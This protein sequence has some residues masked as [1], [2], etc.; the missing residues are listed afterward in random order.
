MSSVLRRIW[1]S[2]HRLMLPSLPAARLGAFRALVC[3]TAL[4]DVMLYSPLVFADADLVG[5]AGEPRPWTP[6]FLFQVLGVQPI[7]PDAALIAYRIAIVSLLLGALG[8]CSRWSCAIGALAFYYWTGLAY[9]FGKP[10]HDK[11]ALAFAMAAL[12]FARVGAAVSI[13]AFVRSKLGRSRAIEHH[14]QAMPIRLVQA[15]LVLGYFGAGMSKLLLG[16]LDWFNGYTLQGIMLGHKGQ[17]SWWVG[18]SPALCQFQSIGVVTVQA[19]FPLVVLWPASR[20]FFL[21]AATGFHLMT[22]MTMDTGPYMRVWL[23]LFVFTPMERIPAWLRQRLT[24]PRVPAVATALALVAIAWLI[25][26]VACSGAP[27]WGV[28]GLGGLLLLSFARYCF[29]HRWN[30]Q[31]IADTTRPQ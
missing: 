2:F 30:R 13:D 16:G 24:G 25:G 31:A 14:V 5:G 17:W 9:S 23:L 15:T 19:C 3:L 12:P 8:V 26:G 18:Q 21:P 27:L 28:L 20:W 10:H 22:W 1:L 4:Y 29:V 7:G 6:I 11:V